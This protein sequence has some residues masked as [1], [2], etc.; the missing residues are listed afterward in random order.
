M[1]AMQS[2]NDDLVTKLLHAYDE[3]DERGLVHGADLDDIFHILG[4]NKERIL[5]ALAP[6]A[7]KK[8]ELPEVE[9]KAELPELLRNI[10]LA[11][12]QWKER[13]TQQQQ[14][15][16]SKKKAM[17]IASVMSDCNPFKS[18]PSSSPTPPQQ[19]AGAGSGPAISLEDLLKQTKEILGNAGL[20]EETVYYEWTTSYVD[21]SRIYGWEE[22][23]GNV[24][25]ALVG[26]VNEEE[27]D[28]VLF[29]AA[30][31][32]G[33]HGSGKTALAQKVFVHDRVKDAF[34][35]RLWVCVGPPDHFDRFCLLYR[36][37]DNL[38]LDTGKLESI[39]DSAAVVV[40]A[41]ADEHRRTEAKIGVLLFVL[42]TTLYKTGYLIVFDD[43]RAHG[44]DGGWYSNL[45]LNPPKDGEWYE[46]LA[47][48]L[49]KARKSAVLVTCRR[50]EDAR[51]MVRT[52]GVFRPPEM[53]VEEG[54]RL[55]KREY[56]AAKKK[57]EASGWSWKE[58]EDKLYKELEEM[59]TEIVGKCLGLPVAIIEA[60]KGFSVLEHQPGGEDDVAGPAEVKVR[61]VE[62]EETSKIQVAQTTPTEPAD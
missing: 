27:D 40:N 58:E 28:Q 54:W 46:R 56:E 32:A 38:G 29:R 20:K 59:K 5:R 26:A 9:R 3:E 17:A 14:P 19:D 24:V 33:I 42:Y 43:I 18:K 6:E 8:A 35:L 39:V 10:D 50:E 55:F 13:S 23:A 16:S 49:P 52:G 61:G 7:E 15:A 53:G 31:I 47:Y 21:E 62:E 51:I 22:D 57:K 36:M 45:T 44:G 25:D 41:G 1:A 12:R 2:G 34:P 11:H 37:L 4:V 30:G 48:G 60:A